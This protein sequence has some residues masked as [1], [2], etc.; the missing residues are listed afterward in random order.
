MLGLLLMGVFGYGYFKMWNSIFTDFGSY[1]QKRLYEKEQ[2]RR[3]EIQ[4]QNERIELEK[5]EKD[6]LR[7]KKEKEDQLKIKE[8]KKYADKLTLEELRN[9]YDVINQSICNIN[10]QIKNLK[11]KKQNEFTI[12]ENKYNELN[13]AELECIQLEKE[14]KQLQIEKANLSYIQLKQKFKLRKEIKHKNKSISNLKLEAENQRNRDYFN[15]NLE[16]KQ[17][18]QYY[19]NNISVLINNLGELKFKLNI[20][21]EPLKVRELEFQMEKK[22]KEEQQIYKEFKEKHLNI[23]DINNIEFAKYIENSEFIKEI[24]CKSYSFISDFEN[25]LSYYDDESFWDYVRNMDL[26]SISKKVKTYSSIYKTVGNKNLNNY[27]TK[28]LYESVV[29]DII[30]KDAELNTIFNNL[31]NEKMEIS[32]ISKKIHEIYNEF[33][34]EKYEISIN[35]TA[36]ENIIKYRK[37]DIKYQN[38]E[39]HRELFKLVEKKFSSVKSFPKNIYD[40]LITQNTAISLNVVYRNYIISQKDSLTLYRIVNM[41]KSGKENIN[42]YKYIIGEE[43]KK[44]KI[45]EEKI[46]LKETQEKNKLYLQNEKNRLI[47]GDMSKEVKYKE[48]QKQKLIEK[49]QISL[50]FSQIA[51]G[52][53]FE[54]YVAKLYEK[55]GYTIDAITKKSGDQRCRCS[56]I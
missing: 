54:K 25:V 45:K 27:I 3:K 48:L 30:F 50:D 35:V 12:L 34:K 14:I 36:L 1:R 16:L 22:Q 42:Y 32:Y 31:M 21:E 55:L 52:Y 28:K 44:I 15:I 13:S 33:Y 40:I 38:L 49:E 11:A 41:I 6:R 51:N 47:K 8:L 20:L 18:E 4:E 29:Y 2:L 53:E 43:K 5:Q 17:K 37:K 39:K 56:G 10:N 9:E 46:K 23:K 19:D 26:S 7:K 24:I